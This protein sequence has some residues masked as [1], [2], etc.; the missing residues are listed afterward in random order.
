MTIQKSF[1]FAVVVLVL[2]GTAGIVSAQD[3]PGYG[4]AY[5]D[6]AG[7]GDYA[8]HMGYQDGT[9]DGSRDRAT[10]HSFRPTQ[11]SHYKHAPEYGHPDINRD[12]YKSLYRDAYVRGYE[13]GYGR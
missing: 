1:R 9:N 4:H 8:T 5:R 3:P 7:P 2:G 11:D 6:Q 12:A 13:K 10:G